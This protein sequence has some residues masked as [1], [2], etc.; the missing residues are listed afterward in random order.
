MIPIFPKIVDDSAYII[1]S[2][3]VVRY[4][5]WN[6]IYTSGIPD[7]LM[8]K[9]YYKDQIGK[10][11]LCYWS[12]MFFYYDLI[13]YM[14]IIFEEIKTLGYVCDTE[15]FII[16]INSYDLSCIKKTLLCRY[17]SSG[18][19]DNLKNT[20]IETLQKK[21]NLC[22]PPQEGISWMQILGND[23][24]VFHVYPQI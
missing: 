20:M 22:C 1:T 4:A 15:E 12:E 18:I 10:D 5:M 23:C 14:I 6:Y 9:A 19:L 16:Q 17:G 11:S 13:E 24:N 21:L 3:E 8:R 7:Q 2:Q